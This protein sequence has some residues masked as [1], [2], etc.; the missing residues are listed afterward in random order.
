MW[1]E[2]QEINGLR[3]KKVLYYLLGSELFYESV[4]VPKIV[5]LEVKISPLFNAKHTLNLDYTLVFQPNQIYS[6]DQCLNNV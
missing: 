2:T 5:S 4:C 3:Q 6:C 1:G